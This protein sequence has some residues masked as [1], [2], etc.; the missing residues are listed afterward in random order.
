IKVL[1]IRG[2]CNDGID[3]LQPQLQPICEWINRACQ[4]GGKVLVHCRT[5]CGVTVTVCHLFICAI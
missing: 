2:M 1:D 3:M 5:G 4:D